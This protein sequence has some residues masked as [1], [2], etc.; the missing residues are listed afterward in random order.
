MRV[1]DEIIGF[2]LLDQWIGSVLVSYSILYMMMKC[3]PWL[4]CS[5][6][7]FIYIIASWCL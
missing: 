1:Y 4:A 5:C 3:L 7:F 2:D 6:P